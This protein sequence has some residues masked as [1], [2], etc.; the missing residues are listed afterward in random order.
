M[1][2]P[3][4]PAILMR[5]AELYYLEDKSQAE[6]A[7]ILSTGRPN[8][9]RML[10][11]AQRQGI[12][13]I[14]VHDPSGRARDLERR[15]ADAFGLSE[16]RVSA[17]NPHAGESAAR[18]GSLVS[19]LLLES[20][21]ET[22]TVGLSWGRALHAAVEAMSTDRDHDVT[23]VQLLGGMSAIGNEVSGQELARSLAV[24][25]GGTYRLMHAPATLGS[26]E[27]ARA[28]REEPSVAQA[29]EAA[30]GCDVALVG[31]GT[32]SS[33]S[34]A[35]VV[36][37]LALSP[38]DARAFW[39]QEPVG[40]LAGRY[41][42]ATGA[43]VTGPVDDRVVSVSLRDLDAIP[44]VVGVAF[45]R[46]KTAAV[47]GALLGHHVDALVCDESLARSLL[48]HQSPSTEGTT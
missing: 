7:E 21:A 36:D 47:Y 46:D 4:D 31:I 25:L 33:G 48:T 16:V 8:V 38:E 17:R 39:D 26:A 35:A 22:T 20:L 32:P 15:L 43:P 24:A 3:R 14:K 23:V 9:S 30:R 6:I 19:T 28:L 18:V 12:V 1:P 37:S 27:A 10:K 42:T 2:A 13:E 11:E 41:F 29:L 45:G 40:D 5:V 34:S 44:L